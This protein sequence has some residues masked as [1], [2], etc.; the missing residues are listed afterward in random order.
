MLVV[1]SAIVSVSALL[2]RNLVPAAWRVMAILGP[3]FVVGGVGISVLHAATPDHLAELAGHEP[4]A[5]GIVGRVEFPPAPSGR[6]CRAH[7]RARHH[8]YQW[9]EHLRGGG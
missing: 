6:G 1:A 5:V 4:G 7:V 2:W 8:G 3:L 9:K